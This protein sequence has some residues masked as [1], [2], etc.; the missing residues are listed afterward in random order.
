[1]ALS[2]SN[3][4][5]LIGRWLLERDYQFITITPLTHAE[6]RGQ[7]TISDMMRAAGARAR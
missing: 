3:A 6:Q 4:L 1:M 5:V 7:R 2:L